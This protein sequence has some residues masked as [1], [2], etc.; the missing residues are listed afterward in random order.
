MIS[1]NNDFY[2]SKLLPLLTQS[3]SV[4]IIEEIATGD[5]HTLNLSKIGSGC[6]YTTIDWTPQARATA[7]STL[8]ITVNSNLIADGNAFV[9]FIWFSYYNNQS[10]FFTFTSQT[11][12]TLHATDAYNPILSGMSAGD[13]ITHYLMAN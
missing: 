10:M 7:P 12:H 13:K 2:G 11:D 1:Y 5:T 3:S 4:K 6:I 8:R 9:G